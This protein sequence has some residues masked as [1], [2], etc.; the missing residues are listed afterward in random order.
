MLNVFELLGFLL[1]I[2]AGVYALATLLI[3]WGLHRL[4][5]GERNGEPTVSVIVPA[6]DEAENIERCLAS[7]LGQDY[8]QE[9]YAIVVVDD[10]SS[11]D[12][13]QRARSILEQQKGLNYKLIR[14]SR[15]NPQAVAETV[16]CASAEIKSGEM[17]L[18][19]KKK[20]LSCGIAASKGEVLLFTDADCKI[21]PGWVRAVVSHFE[22]E[23]GLVAGFTFR[24]P[25]DS[26]WQKLYSLESLAT[27][28]ISAGS[29]GWGYPITGSASNLAYRRSLFDQI[30]GFKD[31][32]SEA[33]GDDTLFLQVAYRK[34]KAKARFMSSP[35]SFV[36]T[37]VP[38]GSVEALDQRR[39]RFATTLHF[40]PPLLLLSG[41]VFLFYLL[42]ILSPIG[43][44]FAPRF[45]QLGLLCLGMK[46][47]V[48]LLALRKSTGIFQK[49]HLLKYLPFLEL[50]YPPFFVYCAVA[51]LIFPTE[52]KGRKS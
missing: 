42:L 29:I 44:V 34:R 23:V 14:L 19:G 24:E 50:V 27:A 5:P 4:K 48:D 46:F 2:S 40:S 20:A 7:L 21:P 30:G 52:W 1:L 26:L 10:D 49:R 33:S 15:S 18:F 13:Y 39:R 28:T 6:R 43:I 37:N 11:D 17:Q 32:G 47:V 22:P 41:L 31:I 35:G 16:G 12:T 8:P 51:G 25:G 38:S 36:T 45:F 3:F 9:K